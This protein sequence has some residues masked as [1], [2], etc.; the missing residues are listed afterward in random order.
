MFSRTHFMG[1][2]PW[3]RLRLGQLPAGTAVPPTCP[4]G[5]HATLTMVGTEQKWECTPLG[6]GEGA[7]PAHIPHGR[8]PEP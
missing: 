1:A 8:D 6:E 2:R 4:A 5:S 3:T 7:A